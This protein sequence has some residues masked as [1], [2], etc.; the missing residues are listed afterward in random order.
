MSSE[1]AGALGTGERAAPLLVSVRIPVLALGLLASLLWVLGATPARALESDRQQP[2][3]VNADATGG[4]LGDGVT[5]LLGNVEIRQ[6]TLH[7]RADEAEVDKRD[8]KVRLV[9]LRGKPVFLEQE[10][11]EQ[12]LVQAQALV[13]TYEVGSGVVELTGAA[14]VKHPQYQISG[15]ALTY[16]LNTQH[17]RGS[18]AES[19]GGRIRIQ[20]DPEV[21]PNVSPAP[22]T[23]GQDPEPDESAEPPAAAADPAAG[24]VS[25]NP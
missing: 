11:E 16:D 4:S 2:L 9:T 23:E 21:A 6:G 19:E 13:I 12:G 18:G 22:T 25:A 17:F 14:D 7:I 1:R 8:G 5:T 15:E 24:E 20:L 3:N 10:I